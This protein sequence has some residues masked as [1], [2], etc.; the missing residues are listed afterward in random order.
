MLIATHGLDQALTIADRVL[1]LHGSPARLEAD[2]SVAG[3]GSAA[4]L[5]A[6][7]LAQFPFLGAEEPAG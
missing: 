6:R 2:L 1:V 5:R 4:A 3:N 7:L